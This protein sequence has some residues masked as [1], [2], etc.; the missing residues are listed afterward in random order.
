MNINNTLEQSN[1]KIKQEIDNGLVSQLTT[2]YIL[3]FVDNKFNSIYWT[4][5]N[6]GK[7]DY[8]EMGVLI[9]Q[10]FQEQLKYFIPLI[11][12]NETYLQAYENMEKVLN[13]LEPRILNTNY[14]ETHNIDLEI[15]RKDVT[16]VIK[17]YFEYEIKNKK[18]AQKITHQEH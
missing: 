4:E 11:F 17:R 18:Q 10:I 16:S 6:H 3:K 12:E 13:K 1:E 8:D 5:N 9:L 15:I 14:I 7:I 2:K